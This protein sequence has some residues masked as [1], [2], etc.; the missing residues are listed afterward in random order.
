MTRATK[1]R[2]TGMRNAISTAIAWLLLGVVL[3]VG[4]AWGITLWE[5]SR[6]NSTFNR[7]WEVS[8]NRMYAASW[9]SPPPAGWA[10]SV[11]ASVFDAD[12]F[13]SRYRQWVWSRPPSDPDGQIVGLNGKLYADDS[14]LFVL[15]AGLPLHCLS[16]E[17]WVRMDVLGYYRVVRPFWRSGLVISPNRQ[18][19]G[20]M[21]WC[22]PLLPDWPP[23]IANSVFWGGTFW[24]TTGGLRRWRRARRRERGLCL[25]CGYD[26]SGLASGAAC[27]ECGSVPISP[28]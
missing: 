21:I 16:W 23:F 18:V 24:L 8:G 22:L 11:R 3:N 10:L 2:K 1:S 14:R 26:R 28:Q 9:P 4:L 19:Y 15:D 5:A 6:R 17:A 27:P 13:P 7:V 12:T 25:S 20:A